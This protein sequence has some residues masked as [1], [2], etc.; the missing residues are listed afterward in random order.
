M[1]S[2]FPEIYSFVPSIGSINQKTEFLFFSFILTVSSEIIG[3]SGVSCSIFLLINSLTFKSPL[4][5]GD[6][7]SLISIFNPFLYKFIDS[8][9]AASKI[10]ISSSV[11]F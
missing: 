5:T 3:M 11:I 8:N 10:G 1:Y 6:P 4:L 2:S 7:S 9:P